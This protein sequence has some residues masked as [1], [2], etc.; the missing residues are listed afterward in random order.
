MFRSIE[1]HLLT[2]FLGTWHR[3]DLL[4]FRAHPSFALPGDPPRHMD[5]S[6]QAW[7]VDNGGVLITAPSGI[8]YLEIYPDGKG[9]CHYWQEFSDGP[10]SPVQRQKELTEQELRSHLPEDQRKARLKLSIKSVAGGSHDIEDFALLASKASRVKLP[11]GQLWFRSSKLGLSQMEGSRPE[12]LILHSTIQQTKL[13]TQVRFYHGNSL[14]GIEFYYEDSTSQ[15]FGKRGGAP[16]GS[17]FNL[18]RI[19][20]QNLGSELTALRY[21]QGRDHYW[22]LC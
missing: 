7:P 10:N 6:V 19:D 12:Q 21:T 15:L 18:G 13:L 8:A 14:D 3:L 2:L 22:F 9:E 20:H 11:N 1:R 4:R 17:E 16:G 5:D